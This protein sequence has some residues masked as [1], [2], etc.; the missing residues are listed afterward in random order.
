MA[1]EQRLVRRLVRANAFEAEAALDPGTMSAVT[2]W[3]LSRLCSTGAVVATPAGAL[4]VEQDAYR[5][6]RRRRRVRA[7]T[8]AAVLLAALAAYLLLR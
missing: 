4:R 3:R 6:L 8:A 1:A 5:S 2:R 7:L